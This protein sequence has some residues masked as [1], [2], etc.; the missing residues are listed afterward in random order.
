MSLYSK[1]KMSP[2]IDLG[3]RLTLPVPTLRHIKML[4]TMSDKELNRLQIIR[5]VC[6]HRLRRSDAANVL[7]LSER[8]VQRLMNRFRQS[9]ASGLMHQSRGKP[10]NNQISIDYR[11][12]IL[13]IVREC[14]V[15]FAPTLAQEKLL[16]QHN[17]PI[18]KETLRQ[19]MISSGL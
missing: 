6:E 4:V 10:S 9:G 8:Q 19:W 13:K 1:V 5:D 2:Y 11:Y 12:G 18:S 3:L 17:L 16:E 14:Y 15:D 7:N